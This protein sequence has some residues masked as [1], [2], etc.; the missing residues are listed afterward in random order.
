MPNARN[1]LESVQKDAIKQWSD[2]SFSNSFL[3][4]LY[5]PLDGAVAILLTQQPSHLLHP[6]VYRLV[7]GAT[8]GPP[9]AAIKLALAYMRIDAVLSLLYC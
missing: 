7:H 6:P 4:Y 8:V 5:A 9:P 1:Q 2:P 3:I